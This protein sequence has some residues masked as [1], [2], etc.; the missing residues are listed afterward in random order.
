MR[1]S[2]ATS[3]RPTGFS[4]RRSL[5]GRPARSLRT[6]VCAAFIARWTLDVKCVRRGL[7]SATWPAAAAA[8]FQSPHRHRLAIALGLAHSSLH[9]PLA[10]RFGSK[11]DAVQLLQEWVQGVGSEAGLTPS[12]TSLSTGRQVG[13]VAVSQA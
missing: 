13:C 7:P 12:N 4:A 8:V 9:L 2:I 5:V 10:C 6:N 11:A 1:L 3:A